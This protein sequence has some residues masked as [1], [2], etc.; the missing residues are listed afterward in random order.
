MKGIV[1]LVPTFELLEIADKIRL[2]HPNVIQ[3][4]RLTN[5]RVEEE[6]EEAVGAGA[7][8]IVARGTQADRIRHVV[9][10]PVVDIV[11]TAQELGLTI[12]EAR[13]LVKKPVKTIGIVGLK[14][15]FCDTSHFDKLYGVEVKTFYYWSMDEKEDMIRK[16]EESEVDVLLGTQDIL[17]QLHYLDF[18]MVP[19]ISTEESLH[20]AANQAESLYYASEVEQKNKAQVNS[21][22]DSVFN[23]LIQ[24]D[25][26]GSVVMMNRVME[27]II[28]KG[29]EEVLGSHIR[30][31]VKELNID[32]VSQVLQSPRESFSTFLNINGK[33]MVMILSPIVVD[34]KI[35]GAYLSLKK[36]NKNDE[37][38]YM[39]A[40]EGRRGDLV[41]YRTFESIP[42]TSEKMGKLIEQAKLYAQSNTPLM[43]EAQ[44][45]DDRESICQGIH[46]YSPR[47]SGPYVTVSMVGMPEEKQMELLF[48]SGGER[49]NSLRVIGALEKAN[50]GTI[51]ITGIGFASVGTQ[52][53]LCRFIRESSGVPLGNG[54]VK[55]LNVR[56]IITSSESLLQMR[57]KN[58]VTFTFYYI[59]SGLV[60]RIPPLQERRKDIAN[61]VNIYLK[62][63]TQQYDRHQIMTPEAMEYLMDYEW[64]G[65]GLQIE[66]FV[67]RMVLTIEKRTIKRYMVETLLQEMYPD[68]IIEHDNSER[69]VKASDPYEKLL[70]ETL[71]KHSGNRND[72]AAELGISL[73]TLW[74][75]MKKYG[76][77]D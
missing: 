18:P 73:T 12:L 28:N 26:Y 3:C 6:A 5:D 61:F 65:S 34:D 21:L 48:G 23:G 49:R 67:E 55:F 10:I 69:Q 31:V 16:L 32:L 19:V 68:E 42:Y 30:N 76:L 75:K 41:A 47:K 58:I 1:F 9:N 63:Y 64:L 43:I 39:Q 35:T 50:G 70:K 17:L 33:A 72:T 14:S 45:G 60:L 51:V 74:R 37:M 71:L 25:S 59:F 22:L 46:N 52:S 66:R 62:K 27:G 24:I 11:W 56:I 40:E 44:S 77:I 8:V 53:A 54:D 20:L 4:K 29:Q 13:K 7:S 2:S 36:I 57:R 15:M 38:S